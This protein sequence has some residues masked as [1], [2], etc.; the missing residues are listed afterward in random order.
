MEDD[1]FKDSS[2]P[3]SDDNDGTKNEREASLRNTIKELKDKLNEAERELSRIAPLTK[4]NSVHLEGEV[5]YGEF[6]GENM[7]TEEGKVFAVPPNYASKSKMVEGD[8]LKLTITPD[9]HFIFKQIHPADRK[10]II[11]VLDQQENGDY[12][13]KVGSKPYKVL[14]AS[15]TYYRA[16]PGD[17]VAIILPADKDSKFAALDSVVSGTGAKRGVVSQQ[18]ATPVMQGDHDSTFTQKKPKGYDDVGTNLADQ[19][20][21]S[22]EDDSDIKS[23]MLDASLGLDEDELI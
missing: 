7:V 16:K 13:V 5:Y 12:V 17:E 9:G 2:T 1:I 6:D 15:V 4:R 20:L 14:L 21:G 3:S 11:G 23:S 18:V 10:R 22:L 19:K 8:E